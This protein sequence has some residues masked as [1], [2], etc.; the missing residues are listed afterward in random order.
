MLVKQ[1]LI[2][3]LFNYLEIKLGY[4]HHHCVIEPVLW[5]LNTFIMFLSELRK[6][7]LKDYLF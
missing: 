2:L 4:A 3:E 7:G 5:I 6:E 1:H